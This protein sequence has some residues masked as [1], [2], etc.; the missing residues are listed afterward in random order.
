MAGCMLEWQ[1]AM[2]RTPEGGLIP[3]NT[4]REYLASS[5]P[6]ADCWEATIER[7]IRGVCEEE[8]GKVELLF[9]FHRVC[10]V[11]LG[12]ACP[13]ANQ[14]I[15]LCALAE[16]RVRRKESRCVCSPRP[17]KKSTVLVRRETRNVLSASWPS[18]S[19]AKKCG[20]RLR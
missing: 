19:T 8:V 20:S 11:R 17:P 14:R 2:W 3:T 4:R 9:R 6:Y 16:S 13:D 18:R 1:P 15:A 5:K 10:A 7:L 12:D